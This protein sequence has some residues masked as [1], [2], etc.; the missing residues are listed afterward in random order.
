[1]LGLA[2]VCQSFDHKYGPRSV[3]GNFCHS[4]SGLT[5]P[6]QTER[7]DMEI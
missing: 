1:M 4:I 5:E 6:G 7:V 3:V 2:F